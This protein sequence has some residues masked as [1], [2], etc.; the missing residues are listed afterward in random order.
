MVDSITF[1][2]LNISLLPCSESSNL[3]SVT[4]S[5][6]IAKFAL[7]DAVQAHVDMVSN[8]WP[9]PASAFLAQAPQFARI[10]SEIKATN[11]PIYLQARIHVDSALNIPQWHLALVNYHDQDLCDFLDFGWPVVS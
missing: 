7:D 9:L 4:E 1:P 10:Y 2:S 5:D 8:I 11:L 6:I 3:S